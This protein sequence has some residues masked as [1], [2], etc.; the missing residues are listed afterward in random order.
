MFLSH[1]MRAIS[2]SFT[3]VP[4]APIITSATRQ[5]N[6]TDAILSFTTPETWGS[7]IITYNIISTPSAVN[8][9][10]TPA[11][12]TGNVT[13]TGLNAGTTYTFAVTATNGV[14]TSPSNITSSVSPLTLLLNYFLVGGGGGGGNAGG[15]GGGGIDT[16]STSA[17]FGASY[18][19]TVA[20]GGSYGASGGAS[21]FNA[22]TAGG[23][24]AGGSPNGGGSAGSN[25]GC[26]GGASYY[27]GGASPG[28][29]SGG[30]GY[31]S[32]GDS[33]YQSGSYLS[34]CLLYTSPSPRDR[35]KSRMP[36][37]A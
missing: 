8:T 37:S 15:G 10:V 11:A 3:R 4:D 27:T 26:G 22:V 31:T 17:N 23:G 16:G 18:S 29:S 21:V 6:N 19:V 24:G 12:Y 32:G 14:G 34:P 2:R 33:V 35:Q 25:G 1:A 7:E 5:T 20:G 28:G 13:L 9:T 30:S 36:S